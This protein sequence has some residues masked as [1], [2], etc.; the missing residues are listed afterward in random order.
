MRSNRY[1]NKQAL[2]ETRSIKET[3]RWKQVWDWERYSC[4]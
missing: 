4:N 3:R 1:V 2:P